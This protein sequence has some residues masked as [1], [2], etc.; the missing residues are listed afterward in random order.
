MNAARTTNS[1]SSRNITLPPQLDAPTGRQQCRI[2]QLAPRYS[3]VLL[4]QK[5][6]IWYP[7]VP[8]GPHTTY[9]HTHLVD[10]KQ[11]FYMSER[12]EGGSGCWGVGT[13]FDRISIKNNLNL[14]WEVPKYLVFILNWPE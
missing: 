6:R 2:M 8:H 14:D 12:R 10:S 5:S 3:K 4:R 7:C 9:T 13:I 11:K 1:P